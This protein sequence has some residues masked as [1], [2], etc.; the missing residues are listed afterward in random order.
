MNHLI[1]M[2]LAFVFLPCILANYADAQTIESSLENMRCIKRFPE[3]PKVI[4]VG[5]FRTEYG[6]YFDRVLI[7]S[8]Y[9]KK[10]DA[11]LSKNALAAFGWGQANRTER[12]KLAK[13]RVEQGLL[14][15]STVVYTKTKDLH[16]RDFQPPQVVSKENGEIIVTLWIQ[17]P[18]GMIRRKPDFQRLEFNFT[19]D[20]SLSPP[21]PLKK[22]SS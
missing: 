12:E 10:D 16:D 13:R 11:T 6:C 19:K 8:R 18:S 17:L 20:G 7:N 2:L 3:S 22:F 4:I 21:T 5:S 14:A 1:K 15:F 9:F